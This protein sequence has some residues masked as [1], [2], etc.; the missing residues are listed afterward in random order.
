[1]KNR[2]KLLFALFILLSPINAF[3]LKCDY[4]EIAELRKLSANIKTS[5]SYVENGD[6]V[7]FN[8]TLTNLD[9]RFY[10]IDK[11][12]NNKYTYNGNKEITISGYKPGKSLEYY[13]YSTKELCTND[14]LNIK[15]ISL[16]NYNKY[17]KDPLCN[18]YENLSI[19]SKWQMNN[20]T[21]D[22]FVKEINNLK[23]KKEETIVEEKEV[24][25]ETVFDIIFFYISKYY[26][27]I[28]LLIAI[29]VLVTSILKRKK[30]E[31][32]F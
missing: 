4:N 22:Q 9:A 11:T 28:I 8:V 17:Y 1:M 32:K 16:P 6:N 18:G 19:C 10:I 12:T 5:Y 15:Y 13:I 23:N 27:Y 14:Y 7:T 3:A 26:L 31:I 30:D 2:L 25:T 29:I 24:V 21:Y 20:L